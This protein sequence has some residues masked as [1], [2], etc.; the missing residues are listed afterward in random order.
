MSSTA[1]RQTEGTGSGAETVVSGEHASSKAVIYING[2][3]VKAVP[4]IGKKKAT[5]YR[6][7]TKL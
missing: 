6:G 5:A 1:T 3:A 7:R 2:A 4:Y